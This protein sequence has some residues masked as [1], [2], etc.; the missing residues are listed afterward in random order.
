MK[1]VLGFGKKGKMRPC[2]IV[3]FEIIQCYNVAYRLALLLELSVVHDV[4]H[5]FMIRKFVHNPSYVVNYQISD[6]EK[7]LS[8][9][10]VLFDIL[11]KM[12]YKIRIK[13]IS[14]VKVQWL[15]HGI[16]EGTWKT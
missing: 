5:L 1:G 2:Y 4:F 9:K 14:L 6:I 10:E 12:V 11:D 16:E 7:G 15:Y 13:K 3:P 8:Y